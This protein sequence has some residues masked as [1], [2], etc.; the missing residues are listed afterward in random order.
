MVVTDL[1]TL[2]IQ[3]I[4]AHD[5]MSSYPIDECRESGKRCNTPRRLAQRHME[6][7]HAAAAVVHIRPLA[8]SAHKDA[9][10]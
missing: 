4:I 9:G 2:S 1:T 5:S 3:S 6:H 10:G 8:V 7:G